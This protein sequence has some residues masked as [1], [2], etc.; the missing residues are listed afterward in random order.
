M[1]LSIFLL[2]S[3]SLEV[4]QVSFSVCKKSALINRN[5]HIFRWK[6]R[7][8]NHGLLDSY[9]FTTLWKITETHL[10]KHPSQN[11]KNLCRLNYSR[12]AKISAFQD[13]SV[14]VLG[15]IRVPYEGQTATAVVVKFKLKASYVRGPHLPSCIMPSCPQGTVMCRLSLFIF[16]SHLKI[17][18]SCLSLSSTY[19][20]K[21]LFKYGVIEQI[22][23]YGSCVVW[24]LNVILTFWR[25]NYFFNFSTLCI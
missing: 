3:L 2:L 25:R 4:F 13:S 24:K 18:D 5:Q 20:R 7:Y 16:L 10:D 8:T 1:R 21:W 17:F 15:A 23:T 22:L 11:S 19:K 12:I 14:E 9:T 6:L